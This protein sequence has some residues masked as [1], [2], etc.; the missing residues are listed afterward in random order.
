LALPIRSKNASFPLPPA[1]EDLDG[2]SLYDGLPVR[3]GLK[4]DEEIAPPALDLRVACDDDGRA[5]SDA[6]G[7]ADGDQ[8]VGGFAQ[9][10]T[11]WIVS[12]CQTPAY[13]S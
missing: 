1:G 4:D 12:F 10:A 9:A 13:G 7:G 11:S 8:S 6:G 5:I 2:A 3:E